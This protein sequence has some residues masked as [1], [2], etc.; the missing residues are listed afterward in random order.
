MAATPFLEAQD[1]D[2]EAG[3]ATDE[4]LGNEFIFDTGLSG[5]KMKELGGGESRKSPSSRLWDSM[6]TNSSGSTT[7][8][9]Q[10]LVVMGI[11]E[12]ME[13]IYAGHSGSRDSI[14][15]QASHE[16]NTYLDLM[17]E[18]IGSPARNT[19]PLR[20]HIGQVDDLYV[21]YSVSDESDSR[22]D[23]YYIN[24]M[25]D[26]VVD[27][28]STPRPKRRREGRVER[29]RANLLDTTLSDTGST[30]SDRGSTPDR[31]VLLSPESTFSSY[32]ESTDEGIY[33]DSPLHPISML[34]MTRRVEYPSTASREF[35]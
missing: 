34:Q 23:S 15:T 6:F 17:R 33:G 31:G 20:T 12:R 11:G 18:V 13:D 30:S 10:T 27:T 14:T 22:M 7:L 3:G 9:S 19:R 35:E 32:S 24:L 16:S 2:V 29:E 25:R 8:V 1:W 26:V 4:E 21:G 28:H 5:T